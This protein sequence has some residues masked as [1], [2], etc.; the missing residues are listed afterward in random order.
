MGEVCTQLQPISEGVQDL[1]R[2]P[3]DS[4]W[5]TSQSKSDQAPK[6][7]TERQNWIQDRLNFLKTHIRRK[8]LSKSSD[9]KSLQR[10]ASASAASAHNISRESTD[11]DSMD[12]STHSDTTQQPSICSTTSTSVLSQASSVNQWVMDQF[13]QM[14]T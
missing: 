12:T 5:K 2:I 11:A 7:M 13:A 9:F 4:L 6:E 10:G 14:K 3:N 8:G 1:V